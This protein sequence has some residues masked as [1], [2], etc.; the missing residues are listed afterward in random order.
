MLEMSGQNS[1]HILENVSCSLFIIGDVKCLFVNVINVLL[2]PR[3][4]LCAIVA[5]SFL[6]LL[7]D[8]KMTEYY[9]RDVE[10]EP[11]LPLITAHPNSS[12][13]FI[14]SILRYFPS[15]CMCESSYYLFT[16]VY[17]TVYCSL[18]FFFSFIEVYCNFFYWE[19]SYSSVHPTIVVSFNTSSVGLCL[20]PFWKSVSYLGW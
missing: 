4:Y 15:V 3:I 1:P 6:P 19:S 9:S 2:L 20:S 17:L 12:I 7:I 14:W 10:A 13:I 5:L 8:R 18:T 16:I 11:T